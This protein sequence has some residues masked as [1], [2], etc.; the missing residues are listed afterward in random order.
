MSSGNNNLLVYCITAIGILA[1]LAVVGMTAFG[2]SQDLD[3]LV[4]LVSTALGILGG[5]AV[6]KMIIAKNGRDV[7]QRPLREDEVE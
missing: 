2:T 7:A 5:I 4:G 6:P 3:S 1:L